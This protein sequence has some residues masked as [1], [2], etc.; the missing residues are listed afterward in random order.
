MAVSTC[1][2]VYAVKSERHRERL[3]D[4]VPHFD[5][6]ENPH[7]KTTTRGCL[8]VSTEK[9]DVSEMILPGLNKLCAVR[10]HDSEHSIQNPLRDM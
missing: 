4:A 9:A 6:S 2:I 5:C 3:K 10:F 7:K 1:D 8:L